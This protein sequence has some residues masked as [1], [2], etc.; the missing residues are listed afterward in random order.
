[1]PD[2]CASFRFELNRRQ[3]DWRE[4]WLQ[5]V[6]PYVKRKLGIRDQELLNTNLVS[7]EAYAYSVVDHAFTPAD[8]R[9]AL[10]QPEACSR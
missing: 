8:D 9:V 2:R 4:Q 1:M 6:G 7:D 10:A 5:V 3:G